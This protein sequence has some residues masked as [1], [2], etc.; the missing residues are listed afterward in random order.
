MKEKYPCGSFLFHKLSCTDQTMSCVLGIT[1]YWESPDNSIA[2][3]ST[4]WE[5]AWLA[6]TRVIKRC[7]WL[8]KGWFANQDMHTWPWKPS[9]ISIQIP[10]KSNGRRQEILLKDQKI[11]PEGLRVEFHAKFSTRDLRY[12]HSSELEL[13]RCWDTHQLPLG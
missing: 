10:Y 4:E 2:P 6:S 1:A 7:H 3:H 13:D 12:C 9:L 11:L 5:S 8:Y